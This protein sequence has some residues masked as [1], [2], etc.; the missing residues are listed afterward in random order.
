MK[1]VVIAILLSLAGSLGAQTTLSP[2]NRT[3]VIE[4][5][6]IAEGTMPGHQNFLLFRPD[7]DYAGLREAP[8]DQS[9]NA[10]GQRIQA[11]YD[12]GEAAGNVGDFYENRDGGHSKLKLERFAQFTSLKYD[13]EL[14]KRGADYG[15]KVKIV[16]ERPTIINASLAMLGK[17][18][19][20]SMARL[21]LHNP[22]LAPELYTQYRMSD[23]CFY[24]EHKDHDPK[25][26]DLFAVNTP[27]LI[28]SQGSS[29]SDRPFMNAVAQTLASFR[30][31]VKE[32]LHQRGMLAPTIQMILRWSNRGV[33]NAENYLTGVAQPTVFHKNKLNPEAM[34]EM[35]HAMTMDCLPPLAMIR[36]TAETE[37]QLGVDYFDSDVDEKLLDTPCAI[38]RIARNLNHSRT[39]R[40]SA[41]DSFDIHNRPL[42]YHWVVLRGNEDKIDIRPLNASKTEAEITIAYHPVTTSAGKPSITSHRVDIGVFVDNGE[43]CSPPAFISIWYPPNE[44]RVYS[45]DGRLL[46]VDYQPLA[47]VGHVADPS[48]LFDK[49]WTDAYD[50]N[51]EGKLT[52][53]TRRYDDGRPEE[54]F[55]A[56]GSRLDANNAATVVQYRIAPQD[57]AY[58]EII[59]E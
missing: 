29:G 42:N 32:R 33:G 55:N 43:Y 45:E 6:H 28:I 52:G 19:G 11:W 58:R 22:E 3:V 34:V 8:V 41:A 12:E 38:G 5:A 23:I 17:T 4:P 46:E 59:F 57:D 16:N 20:R 37:P 27:Y 56:Q 53:W 54:R 15:A 14:K 49:P 39:F 35:A 36:M 31:A 24:P 26:G 10:L 1:R 50:Y 40:V 48:L 13:Q 25:L 2:E 18:L 51:A 30:P 7:V 47:E 21:I 44:Q 9:D